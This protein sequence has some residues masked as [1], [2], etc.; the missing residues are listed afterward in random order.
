MVRLRRR[1][2]P[3]KAPCVTPTELLHG[4]A[5]PAKL[6]LPGLGLTSRSS[7][8]RF[9]RAGR[10]G[11]GGRSALLWLLSTT[12]ATVACGREDAASPR[13]DHPASA[14][15]PPIEIFSWFERIGE[16]DPLGVLAAEHRRRYPDDVII[17]ARASGLARKALRGR[18]LRGEPPDA[19]QANVG[20]DLLQWVLVD[21]EDARESKLLPLDGLVA[22]VGSWRK[23]IPSALLERLSYDGK[24]YGVPADLHR[25]NTL[26]YN[27]KVF[28]RYGLG[29]P[30]TVED[31]HAMGE[32][33]RGSGVSLLAVGSR[34]PWTVALLLFECLLVAREGPKFYQDYFAGRLEAADPRFIRTLE[35]GIGLFAYVNPNHRELSWLQAVELVTRGEAA[36]TVMGDWARVSFIAAGLRLGQDYGEIPFPETAGTFL[37]SADAFALPVEA[38]NR[39]GVQRL[40]ATI[41]S[42]EGQRAI[43]RARGTLSA[44][45][46]VPP[47]DTDPVLM[48]SFALLQKKPPVMA[49]SG[50]LP[51]AFADDLAAALGE[52]LDQHDVD[53]VIH[54]LRSRYVLLQ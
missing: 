52:M 54:M 4:V 11:R 2:G 44:R 22:G 36:M 40:L 53:P 51:A 15:E 48:S 45:L 12:L 30:R 32:K 21:G 18:M 27:K 14:P 5:G 8:L 9:D 39:A 47:P 1:K 25:N 31:L 33:L 38:K 19:F 37:F 34:E 35:A 49:L 16:S 20:T 42:P 17:N 23:A 41:G 6:D 29:E 24:I 10:L 50:L 46:D 13:S 26:F 3:R 43:S 7:D 28:A